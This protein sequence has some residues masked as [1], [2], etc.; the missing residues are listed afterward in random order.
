RAAKEAAAQAAK[1]RAAKEA[2]AQAAKER[3][4]KEAAAQAAKER[5]AKEAAAQA[6]KEQ[7]PREQVLQDQILSAVKTGQEATLHLAKTWVDTFASV[8]PK[9]F[10]TVTMPNLDDYY[11]FAERMWSRNCDFVVSLLKIATD[12]GRNM[13]GP[14]KATTPRR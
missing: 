9:L 7:A 14:G 13:P 11:G 5:A 6:A 8:T 10:D 4:A 3:A 2:A 1:E 12:F